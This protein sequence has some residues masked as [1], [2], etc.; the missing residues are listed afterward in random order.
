MLRPCKPL[1]TQ[2]GRDT[3]AQG[4]R[5]KKAVQ[6][7]T[8]GIIVGAELLLE[9]GLCGAERLKRFKFSVISLKLAGNRQA[10]GALLR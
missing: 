4:W 6:G 5:P 1:S 2:A 3:L 7:V 9:D 10:T 8:S